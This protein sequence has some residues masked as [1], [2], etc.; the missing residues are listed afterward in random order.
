MSTPV[1]PTVVTTAT[2]SV[3][4]VHAHITRNTAAIK[5]HAAITE[6]MHTVTTNTANLTAVMATMAVLATTAQV[7]TAAQVIADLTSGQPN[8]FIV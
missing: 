5:A 4:Q 3:P 6:A 8:Q 7:L 2:A 1:I